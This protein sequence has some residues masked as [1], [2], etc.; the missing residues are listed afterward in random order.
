MLS[1]KLVTLISIELNISIPATHSYLLPTIREEGT[2]G[3][4]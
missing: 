2:R 3:L 1:S 4:S